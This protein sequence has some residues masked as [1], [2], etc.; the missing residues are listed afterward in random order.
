MRRVS[1][2]QMN[3]GM[4]HHNYKPTEPFRAFLSRR[5]SGTLSSVAVEE[6][7]GAAKKNQQVKRCRK[8]RRPESS[9]QLVPVIK[10]LVAIVK[11]HSYII[12]VKSVR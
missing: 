7:V 2:Q 5:Y 1:C 6:F 11:W 12:G 8:Y 9:T 3:L 10:W 4:K